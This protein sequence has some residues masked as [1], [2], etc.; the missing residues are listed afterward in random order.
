MTAKGNYKLT[1][2]DTE[3][4]ELYVLLDWMGL[5]P[6]ARQANQTIYSTLG[7]FDDHFYLR[8]R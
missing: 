8:S 5:A 4:R 2:S 6:E 1:L 7:K 3:A